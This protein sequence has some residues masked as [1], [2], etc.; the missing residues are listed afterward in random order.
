MI[1]HENEHDRVA[2]LHT[3]N[4]K[5]SG[6]SRKIFKLAELLGRREIASRG[7]APQQTLRDPIMPGPMIIELICHCNPNVTEKWPSI[8]A[9]LLAIDDGFGRRR[10]AWRSYY[11][12]RTTRTARGWKSSRRS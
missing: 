11:R 9:A 1:R 7:V 12:N 10:A 3:A 5:I 6:R 4:W 2:D 8:A